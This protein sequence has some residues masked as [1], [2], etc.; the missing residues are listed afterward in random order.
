M[1]EKQLIETFPELEGMT[2]MDVSGQIK[3]LTKEDADEIRAKAE[4][5]EEPYLW[6][7]EKVD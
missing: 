4:A 7:V 6:I 5:G 1:Y 3:A 2:I